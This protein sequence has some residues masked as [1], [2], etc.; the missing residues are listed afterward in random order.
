MSVQVTRNLRTVWYRERPEIDI[1][2]KLGDLAVSGDAGT[3]KMGM[4]GGRG[5]ADGAWDGGSKRQRASLT[6][7]SSAYSIFSALDNYWLSSLF[8]N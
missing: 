2:A 1:L 8:K 4:M 7:C 3:R 5:T 6:W